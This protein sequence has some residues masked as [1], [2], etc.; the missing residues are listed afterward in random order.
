ML[1]IQQHDI[2]MVDPKRQNV[3]SERR[4]SPNPPRFCIP[5]IWRVCAQ[6][7]REGEFRRG[8][9]AVG[10]LSLCLEVRVT[11]RPPIGVESEEYLD[12]QTQ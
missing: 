7:S 2:L 9:A 4:Y 11:S 1:S 6:V 8:V 3:R 12:H 10:C 5:E